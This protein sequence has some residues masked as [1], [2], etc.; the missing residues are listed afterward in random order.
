MV[1]SVSWLF[2]I[3]SGPYQHGLDSDPAVDITMAAGAFGQ[4]VSILFMGEGSGYLDAEIT[5]GDN[6]T[7]LRK[8]LKSLPFYDINNVYLL[9]D[10]DL[11]T[12]AVFTIPAEIIASEHASRLIAHADHVV[13]F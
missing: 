7:D 13:S 9:A 11:D 8:L 6:Q 12:K 4:Q 10:E 2:V 5:P 1:N 3:A